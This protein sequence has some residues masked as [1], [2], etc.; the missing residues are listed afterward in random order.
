[1]LRGFPGLTSELVK[2]ETNQGNAQ[3]CGCRSD[4]GDDECV[5]L[6]VKRFWA[7]RSRALM[8]VPGSGYVLGLD[9]DH[10]QAEWLD[11]QSTGYFCLDHSPR[12]EQYTVF[13]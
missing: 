3:K 10:T 13:D 7:K 6:S 4:H 5:P 11:W 1:M 9:E 8:I 12:G 2:K